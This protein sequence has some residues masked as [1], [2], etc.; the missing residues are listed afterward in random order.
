MVSLVPLVSHAQIGH[1]LGFNSNFPRSYPNLF[2]D[3]AVLRQVQARD[4][5]LCFWARYFTCKVPL[6]AQVYK[7]N[8][9]CQI[10]ALKDAILIPRGCAPYGQYQEL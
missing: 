3:R 1:L 6:S 9:H 7:L 5:V 8:F 2:M 10:Q 4:P